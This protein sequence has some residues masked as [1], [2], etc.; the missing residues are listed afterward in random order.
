[1]YQPTSLPN[2]DAPSKM[3]QVQHE[4]DY[5]DKTR[6]AIRRRHRNLDETRP[7]IR[8]RHKNLNFILI[9]VCPELRDSGLCDSPFHVILHFNSFCEA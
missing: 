1:M 2:D 9:H 7:A 3:F 4:T 5:A 6:P 8:R